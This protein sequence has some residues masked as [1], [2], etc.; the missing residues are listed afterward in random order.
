V[1]LI[2]VQF[3]AIGLFLISTKHLA[4]RRIDEV[5]TLTSL[6]RH[7]LIDILIGGVVINPFMHV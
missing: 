2:R 4:G 6:A 1:P 7:R 5:R 3:E